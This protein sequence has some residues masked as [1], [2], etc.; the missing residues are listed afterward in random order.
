MSEEEMRPPTEEEL[1]AAFEEQMRKI[2]VEDVILQTAATLLNLAAQRLGLTGDP[3]AERDV[4]QAQ[5]AIEGVRA[6]LPLT[7]E[8]QQQPLREALSQIQMA[9][10][11]VAQGREP[12]A[13]GAAPP[14]ESPEGAEQA[15]AAAEQAERAKA[16][17][18]L[19]TPPGS[20]T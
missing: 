16:R 6:L 5:L 12:G 8:Q 10:A 13:P 17:E 2:R 18:K 4:A 19:W 3:Q 11:N 15:A 9:F 20:D 7:P 14:A 1:Q